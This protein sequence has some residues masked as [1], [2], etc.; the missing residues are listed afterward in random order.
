[1]LWKNMADSTGHNTNFIIDR[2]RA[3]E[4]GGT[5]ITI[6]MLNSDRPRLL[7]NELPNILNSIMCSG[8]LDA[9]TSAGFDYEFDLVFD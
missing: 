7:T 6:K 1:M 9:S 8:Y 5:M 3:F 4:N 2:R